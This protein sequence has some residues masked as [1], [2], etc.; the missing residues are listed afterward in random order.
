MS[1][2]CMSVRKQFAETGASIILVS[3][4]G[5][6]KN[7]EKYSK[8]LRNTVALLVEGKRARLGNPTCVSFSASGDRLSG[9][10]CEIFGISQDH[11]IWHIENIQD[12]S[13]ILITFNQFYLPRQFPSTRR[14]RGAHNLEW[15]NIFLELEIDSIWL[16][17]IS[18]AVGTPH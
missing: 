10:R 17:A 2:S 5:I 14:W 11:D 7:T 16:V 15:W 8:I 4:L 12:I 1:N 18:F 9:R 3:T 6:L 13:E